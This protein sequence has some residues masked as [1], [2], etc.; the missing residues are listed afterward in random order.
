MLGDASRH[1]KGVC[2]LVIAR[3]IWCFGELA[4][5]IPLSWELDSYPEFLQIMN[6]ASKKLEKNWNLQRLGFMF[7]GRPL[8]PPHHKV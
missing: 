6:A 3:R 7:G 2:F 4:Y 5:E 1:G 8:P